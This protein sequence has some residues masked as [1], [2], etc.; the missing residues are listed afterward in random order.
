MRFLI[1]NILLVL[2]NPLVVVGQK[3]QT[4]KVI[5]FLN[6]DCPISQDYVL[7]LNKI[8][9]KYKNVVRIEGVF[10]GKVKRRQVSDFSEEYGIRFETKVDK[11]RVLVSVLRATVTP[12]AFLIDQ[13]GQILYAGAIDDWYYELGRHKTE[14]AQNFLVN[15]INATVSGRKIDVPKTKAIGCFIEMK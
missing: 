10:P 1:A 6:V 14:P 4:L 2:S 13:T 3:N 12:E 8:Y 15:A 7:T 5:V 11:R 9:D